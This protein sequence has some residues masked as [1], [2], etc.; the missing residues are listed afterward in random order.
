MRGAAEELVDARYYIVGSDS[1]PTS[2]LMF[3][4]PRQRLYLLDGPEQRL[5]PALQRRA[6]AWLAELM[7]AWGAQCVLAT[8]ALAFMTVDGDTQL[9][10]VIREEHGAAV[11]PLDA[12]EL[13]PHDQ[14]ARELGFDRG[15]LLSRWRAFLFVE[16]QADV[17]VLE[18][19]YG[20]RLHRNAILLTQVLGH[21][22]HAGLVEMQLLIKGAATP[23]AA[24]FD[25]I[26]HDDIER[27]RTDARHRAAMLNVDDE[28][29][30]VA[31]IAQ[32]E[33]E[34]DR[35]IELLTVEEPDVFDCLSERV[36]C[37]LYPRFVG[38]AA[39]KAAFQA[40]GGG[41]AKKR[42]AFYKRAY[43]VPTTPQGLRGIARRMREQAVV[44]NQQPAPPSAC[45][46]HAGDAA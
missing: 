31:R 27:I 35:R 18:E 33:L 22:G 29:A 43:G 14:L 6:A 5:H 38:H 46:S 3:D 20:D 28:R 23:I 16:G 30:T 12:A 44:S 40:A 42:K 1:M 15:E 2:G 32:T 9:H 26:T 7:D 37:G 19:L 39:A 4:P 24:L 11:L 41:N 34:N 17:A 21:R 13:G 25:G 45:S 10:Q 36:I 8:H